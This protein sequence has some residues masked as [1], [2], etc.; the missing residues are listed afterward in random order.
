VLNIA[1]IAGLGIVCI[2]MLWAY[3]L[4]PAALEQ[5]SGHENTLFFIL[6]AFSLVHGCLLP[7]LQAWR[8]QLPSGATLCLLL[9]MLG[10]FG[11]GHDLKRWMVKLS[12]VGVGMLL[13]AAGRSIDRKA[14]QPAG[15]AR[16]SL[17]VP[18][19]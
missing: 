12:A 18:G 14:A 3:R 4:L 13:L 16:Y 2:G 9:P 5:P 11:P 8:Q 7:T 19:H 6:W 10:I 1:C 17:Q 15:G